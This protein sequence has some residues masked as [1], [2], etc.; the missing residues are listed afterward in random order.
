MQVSDH[1]IVHETLAKFV[2][3]QNSASTTY[4]IIKNFT[5]DYHGVLKVDV[6]K[7][8]ISRILHILKEHH[9]RQLKE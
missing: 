2:P 4:F 6:I 7:K 5:F 3:A 8:Y 1:L 9:E